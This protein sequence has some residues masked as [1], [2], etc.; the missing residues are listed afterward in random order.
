MAER[1][2]VD[3]PA[4][5]PA[6]VRN[7]LETMARQR[8][9]YL[10]L[11]PSIVAVFVFSYLPIYGLT[12]A[13]RD[14]NAALGPFASPWSKPIFYNFWFFQDPEF[15]YV[16]RNT[17]RISVLKFVFGWP[18]PILLALLLNE[19]RHSGFKRTVQTI[20]YLPHF[21][22]WVIMAA[23]IYRVLDYQSNSPVNV[24]IGIFGA[25]PMALMGDEQAFIPIVVLSAI[26][27]EIG[28][29]TIIYLATIANINPELYEQAEIDG[30]GKLRQTRH[31]TLP[32]MVPIISILL[33][34][35][36]P[37]ILQAGFDQLYNLMNASTR[38]LAYVTDIYVLRLGLIQGQYS[39]AAALEL[40]YSV[41]GLALV[42]IAN[43]LSKSRAGHGIW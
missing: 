9:L 3:A 40:V 24:I 26:F 22:S 29:G 4:R 35:S 25:E 21:L 41:V 30:A 34:L 8:W 13:F 38:R 28:W 17:V 14:F 37:A 11:A 5:R 7:T 33:V 12:L 39:T 32:G 16:L 19:I 20:S 27:K 10:L 2:T 31:I 43:Y 36:I 23:V 42:L 18:A 6:R 15:W 1:T